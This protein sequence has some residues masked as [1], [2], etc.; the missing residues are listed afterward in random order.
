MSPMTKTNTLWHPTDEQMC[1]EIA[2]AYE[3]IREQIRKLQAT[4]CCPD[5][6]IQVLLVFIASDYA[7]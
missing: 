3:A 6:Y 5:S 2:P 4:T 1:V 7:S